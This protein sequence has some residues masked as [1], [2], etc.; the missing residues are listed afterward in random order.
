MSRDDS[1]NAQFRLTRNSVYAQFR[2]TRHS[3]QTRDSPV[4]L[5]A[6]TRWTRCI[7]GDPISSIPGDADDRSRRFCGRIC[8]NAPDLESENAQFRKRATLLASQCLWAKWANAQFSAHEQMCSLPMRHPR[9]GQF[10]SYDCIGE[11]GSDATNASTYL[12]ELWS[13]QDASSAH[14]CFLTAVRSVI[15]AVPFAI[16]LVALHFCHALCV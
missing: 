9:R 14:Q 12:P 4:D 13:S 6:L 15:I 7:F 1:E 3:L 16:V 8:F 5:L 11:K 10:L 2:L